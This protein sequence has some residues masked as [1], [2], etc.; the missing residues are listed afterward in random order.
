MWHFP[1]GYSPFAFAWHWLPRGLKSRCEGWLALVT[2]PV[3]ALIGFVVFSFDAQLEALLFGGDAR[4]WLQDTFGLGYDQRNALIVGAAMGLA[5]MPVVFS[6]SEQA[7]GGVP[8]HL[9]QGSLALGATRWQ[10]V[11]RII[12][13]TAGPGIFS[14]IMIG[15]GRAVGETMIVLMASGNTPILD[16]NVFQGMRTFAANIAVELPEAEI[17]SSHYRILFLIALLLF[18]MTFA[19][20][21]AAEVVRERLRTRYARL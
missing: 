4:S 11:S 7:I 20:N 12:V 5:V 19:F 16:L 13:L 14:A 21:T 1:S 18:L 2:V 8:A 15:L 9:V 3:L 6:V 17:A 10:T